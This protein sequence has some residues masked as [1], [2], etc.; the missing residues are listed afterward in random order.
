MK[1]AK[2]LFT[3]VA[4]KQQINWSNCRDKGSQE[5]KEMK[6]SNFRGMIVYFNYLG[7]TT[8]PDI[9]FAV[10]ALSRYVKNAGRKHWLQGKHI[11]RY[12][13]ATKCRK[14]T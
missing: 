12:P 2:R 13:M 3:P 6:K 7:N 14:L 11:F 1:D 5:R 4:E 9:T 10:R 8:R